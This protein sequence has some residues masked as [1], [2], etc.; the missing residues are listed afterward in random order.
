MKSVRKAKPADTL[1]G[2]KTSS[3]STLN[4]DEVIDKTDHDWLPVR[5][6]TLTFS[7]QNS[8]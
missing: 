2:G 6:F 5:F 1:L 3:I 8:S 7:S 4:A